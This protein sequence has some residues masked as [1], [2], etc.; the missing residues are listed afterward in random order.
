MNWW[1]LLWVPLGLVGAVLALLIFIILLFSLFPLKVDLSYQEERLF[2]KLR[3]LLFKRML[4]DPD[5]EKTEKKPKKEK[6]KKEKAKPKEILALVFKVLES[7]AKGGPLKMDKLHLDVTFGG[8]DPADLGILFGR[9]HM[10]LG[11]IWPLL[12]KVLVIKDPRINTYI[13]FTAESTK[14]NYAHLLLPIPL[15]RTLIILFKVLLFQGAQAQS[16]EKVVQN[17]S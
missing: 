15:V 5:K 3:I 1:L 14:L 9:V 11:T 17:L 4:V 8:D 12:S 6:P 10:G 2:V 7:L 16:K 13:D